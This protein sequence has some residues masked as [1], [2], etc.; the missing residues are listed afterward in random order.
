MSDL[1]WV[2]EVAE[3]RDALRL[4]GYNAT[5]CRLQERR[6]SRPYAS[7]PEETQGSELNCSA[8]L[9]LCTG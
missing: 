4:A 8:N 7:I 2:A 1:A 5:K 6:P 9:V 3:L